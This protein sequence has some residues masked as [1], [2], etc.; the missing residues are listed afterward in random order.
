[1]VFPREGGGALVPYKDTT[2]G[3]FVVLC[4]KII[5]I[6]D[7]NYHHPYHHKQQQQYILSSQGYGVEGVI[8]SYQLLLQ[9]HP[10]KTYCKR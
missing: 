3:R 6:N 1:M 7:N 2:N 5:T 8:L 4:D 10:E 9:W